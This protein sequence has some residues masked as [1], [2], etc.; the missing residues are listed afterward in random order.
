M[1]TTTEHLATWPRGAL[2]TVELRLSVRRRPRGDVRLY[3]RQ[4]VRN[5]DGQWCPTHRG[6]LVQHRELAPV[7]QALLELVAGGPVRAGA[8]SRRRALEA[9]RVLQPRG[10]RLSPQLQKRNT[11]RRTQAGGSDTAESSARSSMGTPQERRTH[12]NDSEDL[13]DERSGCPSRWPSQRRTIP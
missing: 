8:R 4:W 1:T 12:P 13:N 3:L 5:P 6:I 10:E 7:A 9:L 11:G 2:G